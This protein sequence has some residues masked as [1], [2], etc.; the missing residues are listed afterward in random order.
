M[1]DNLRSRAKPSS[2]PGRASRWRADRA[3]AE[4]ASILDAAVEVAYDVT[5]TLYGANDLPKTDGSRGISDPYVILRVDDDEQQTDYVKNDLDPNF[6]EQRF[7]FPS[8]RASTLQVRVMDKDWTNSD[9]PLGDT[10]VPLIGLGGSTPLTLD[11]STVRALPPGSVTL[12]W[13]RT[14]SAESSIDAPPPIDADASQVVE[15]VASSLNAIPEDKRAEVVQRVADAYAS[16]AVESETSS[17]GTVELS[18]TVVSAAN[19]ANDRKER[20]QSDPYCQVTL[21]VDGEDI[22]TVKTSHVWNDLSP[23]WNET[24]SF[25]IDAAK[26]PLPH[27]V[28]R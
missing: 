18:V 8:T 21:V 2:T 14:V 23:E 24:F 6:G 16:R 12:A 5:V 22:N 11:L 9:D 13:S 25:D 20:S 4:A 10:T 26:V 28:S 17:E 7:T 19:L 27:Y 3:H 1:Q 15:W